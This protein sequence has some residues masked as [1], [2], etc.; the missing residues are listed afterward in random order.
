MP[1]F[2]PL[3]SSVI[4]RAAVALGI[5][6]SVLA[7]EPVVFRGSTGSPVARAVDANVAAAANDPSQ[8]LS[9]PL[10]RVDN[11]GVGTSSIAKRYFKTD[12]L[13]I[14]GAAYLAER[15][16]PLSIHPI[17]L[18]IFWPCLG[19]ICDIVRY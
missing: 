12:V 4:G 17:L 7:A 1:H 14:Y 11:Q 16:A 18:S 5:I 8:V 9:V 10:R 19:F 13:G 3:A 6:S 15:E 2:S